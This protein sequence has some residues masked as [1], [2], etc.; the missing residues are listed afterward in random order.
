MLPLLAS[1]RATPTPTSASSA[2]STPVT[3]TA[4]ASPAGG[5]SLSPLAHATGGDW[6]AARVYAADTISAPS[7][8]NV[9][10][11]RLLQKMS[12]YVT[13]IL[14]TFLFY[15]VFAL[16]VHFGSAL[17]INHRCRYQPP[18][19]A[20]MI[21]F[22]VAHDPLR[23]RPPLLLLPLLPRTSQSTLND[24]VHTLMSFVLLLPSNRLALSLPLLLPRRV[25]LPCMLFRQAI[26]AAVLAPRLCT[27]VFNMDAA[28]F[29]AQR[30]LLWRSADS[31]VLTR[32]SHVATAMET[33]PHLALVHHLSMTLTS[34]RH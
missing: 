28:I 32:T 31:L 22:P 26:A 34:R 20:A 17:D 19:C 4:T 9:W 15:I 3:L 11:F 10:E 16:I 13:R 21:I 27:G 1:S 23:L 2:A 24:I 8:H 18:H 25:P 5:R 7:A 12:Q 29:Y 14:P 33:I 6:P 30:H